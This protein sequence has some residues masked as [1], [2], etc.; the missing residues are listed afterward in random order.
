MLLLM[1]LTA[2]FWVVLALLAGWAI[3]F[4]A[5]IP[6]RQAFLNGLIPSEQRATV[7]SFDNLL[8]SSGG[9]VVQ[10]ALG[11]V[12]DLWGYAASY[13]VAAAIEVLA[14]PL[15][16]LARGRRAPSDPIEVGEVTGPTA[17]KKVLAQRRK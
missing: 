14:V 4:A 10:P 17:T 3:V 9:V 11:K 1:G 15:V 16:L 7:L 2:N 6:I 8:S 5:T 12:A 13:C